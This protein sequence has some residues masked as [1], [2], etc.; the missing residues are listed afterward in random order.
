MHQNT[1]KKTSFL[2]SKS[3]PNE[4]ITNTLGNL[5]RTMYMPAQYHNV[6]EGK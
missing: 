1:R 4:E 6:I 3:K 5:Q 2:I